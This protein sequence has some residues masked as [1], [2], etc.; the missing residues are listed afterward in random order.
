MFLVGH[1]QGVDA[2]NLFKSTCT[3]AIHGKQ[4]VLERQGDNLLTTEGC[5][6]PTVVYFLHRMKKFTRIYPLMSGKL[7]TLANNPGISF[8]RKMSLRAAAETGD[9]ETVRALL[10]SGANTEQRNSVML[11]G[12]GAGSG[13]GHQGWVHASS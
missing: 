10:K 4:G 2:S 3:S 5:K 11:K 1:L 9:L 12:D 6:K 13:V 8:G 7:G